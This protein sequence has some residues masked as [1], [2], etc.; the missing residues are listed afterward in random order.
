MLNAEQAVCEFGRQL[1]IE[2]LTL[3][4]SGTCQLGLPDGSELLVDAYKEALL[5]ALVLP[6]P[7]LNAA[8]MLKSLQM[9][10]LR[11]H[12]A[13]GIVRVGLRGN[14]ADA[15]LVLVARITGL[16]VGADDIRRAWQTLTQ[17]RAR[18]ESNCGRAA[19]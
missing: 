17:W 14:G 16:M 10:D 19:A 15:S 3:G 13:Q 9:A 4:H 5:V 2:G 1:G 11:L 7:F 18:W 12:H 8:E 6:V